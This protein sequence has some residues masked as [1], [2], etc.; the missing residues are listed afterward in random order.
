MRMNIGS[1]IHLFCIVYITNMCRFAFYLLISRVRALFHLETNA[2]CASIIAFWP[3]KYTLHDPTDS[4]I[5]DYIIA[6]WHRISILSCCGMD[7]ICGYDSTAD[8]VKHLHMHNS[9]SV[10][11]SFALQSEYIGNVEQIVEND[12]KYFAEEVSSK[13]LMSATGG[14]WDTVVALLRSFN[15]NIVKKKGLFSKH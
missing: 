1:W 4:N 6:L 3:D 13:V 8:F 5:Y 15:G 14:Y 11:W 7:L 10:A 12:S 9:G 2:L